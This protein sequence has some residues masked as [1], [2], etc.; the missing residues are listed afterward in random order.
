MQKNIPQ[1]IIGKLILK[2]PIPEALRAVISWFFCRILKQK[3]V[4]INNVIGKAK[5]INHGI[6]NK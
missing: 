3:T 4:D 1:I 5:L 6:V 2:I